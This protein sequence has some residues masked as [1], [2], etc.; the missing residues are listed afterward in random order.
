VRLSVR[1]APGIVAGRKELP[2]AVVGS[3]PQCRYPTTWRANRS[4]RS[5][6]QPL[7]TWRGRRQPAAATCRSAVVRQSA[8][9]ITTRSGEMIA[10]AFVGPRPACS[11]R[12]PTI[13]VAIARAVSASGRLVAG[14]SSGALPSGRF[15]KVSRRCP[16]AARDPEVRTGRGPLA[17]LCPRLRK[18]LRRC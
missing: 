11:R 15:A 2:E 5:D 10:L 13:R 4:R 6:Y 9:V 12:S 1:E 16:G 7:A 18:V 3:H 17:A 8:R 14:Q